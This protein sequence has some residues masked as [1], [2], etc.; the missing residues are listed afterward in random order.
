MGRVP[1]PELLGDLGS[2]PDEPTYR[3]LFPSGRVQPRSWL[4]ICAV[5]HPD[6][7]PQERLH[8]GTHYL[9]LAARRSPYRDDIAGRQAQRRRRRP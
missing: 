2:G 4:H 5:A 3:E 8:T 7:I 9:R 6:A 1:D